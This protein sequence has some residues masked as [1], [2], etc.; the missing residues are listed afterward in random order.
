MQADLALI[1]FGNV[2]RSFARLLAQRRDW[3][4]LDYDLECR[5]VGISTRRHGWTFDAEGLDAV[6]VATELESSPGSSLGQTAGEGTTSDGSLEVIR[7][8]GR[9]TADRKVLIET[10]TLD[11]APGQPAID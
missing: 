7:A 3:L 6:Q 2:G 10:T 4:A 1:G 5:I 8:L 9:S 11:L